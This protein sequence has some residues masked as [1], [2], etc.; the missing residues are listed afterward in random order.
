VVYLTLMSLIQG[1]ALLA[2]AGRVAAT[3]PHF[4][5]ADWPVVVTTFLLN[6]ARPCP[7]PG[8]R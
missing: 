6:G 1:V 4:A 5:A 2:L 8:D 3:Y 7:R